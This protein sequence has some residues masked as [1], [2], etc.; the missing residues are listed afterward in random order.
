MD[1]D[2]GVVTPVSNRPKLTITY[3]TPHAQI[4]FAPELGDNYAPSAMQAGQTVNLPVRVKNNGSGF[5]F[6]DVDHPSTDSE[7]TGWYYKVGYRWYDQKGKVMTTPASGTADLSGDG[8]A[9]GGQS[10]AFSLP[11]VAP[12]TPGTYTLRLDLVHVGPNADCSTGLRCLWASDW[13]QGKLYY[14]RDKRSFRSR[15]HALDRRLC[16]RA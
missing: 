11:V 13:A 15:Q 14:A 2:Y 9:D 3:K 12:A 8:V 5:A 7:E 6:N 1:F 16:H 10:A 4:D